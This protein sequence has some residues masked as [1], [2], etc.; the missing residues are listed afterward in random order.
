MYL[1]WSLML[2]HMRT[3]PNSI[4]NNIIVANSIR[5]LWFI[6]LFCPLSIFFDL[7]S[8][9]RLWFFSIFLFFVYLTSHSLNIRICNWSMQRI[10][11]EM[12]TNNE[13]LLFNF[14]ILLLFLIFLFLLFH[15][16]FNAWN[17]TNRKCRTP[18]MEKPENGRNFPKLVNKMFSSG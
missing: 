9:L 15:S 14:S 11:N 16:S 8:L 12:A 7:F 1:L 6:C 10:V 3:W 13:L 4:P 2:C 17:G 5:T 18:K